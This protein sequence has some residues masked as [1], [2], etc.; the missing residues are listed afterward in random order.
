[1]RGYDL[2]T[3]LRSEGSGMKDIHGP[4]DQADERSAVARTHA[5]APDD[6]REAAGPALVSGTDPRLAHGPGDAAG[7]MALQ[8]SAGNAA[9][10]ALVGD[11]P[12]VQRRVE[13]DDMSSSVATAP[14]TA[15]PAQA[16]AS[17]G[18]G[19]AV[20]S[21]GA[22]TTINGAHITL[23]APMTE[24]AGIIRADTI[25]ADNVVAANYTPGAGNVW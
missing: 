2:G 3:E 21:D 22:T 15:A 17:T 11:R 8:R 19:G 12:S 6:S 10:T 1:M 7:L 14:E 24:A 20:T 4:G 13:I 9:V 5:P 16:G 18:S 25:I 23:A